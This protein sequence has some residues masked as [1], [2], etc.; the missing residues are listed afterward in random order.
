MSEVNASFHLIIQ[1]E[2]DEENARVVMTTHQ[3]SELQLRAILAGIADLE[4]ISVLAAYKILE[5]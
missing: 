5:N 2:L 3:I 4:E 1:S